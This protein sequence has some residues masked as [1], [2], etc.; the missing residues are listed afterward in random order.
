MM[1]S[2]SLRSANYPLRVLKNKRSLRINVTWVLWFCF[3]LYPVNISGFGVNYL[4]I[5]TPFFYAL[6]GGRLLSPPNSIYHLIILFSAIYIIATFYQ[7]EFYGEGLRRTI[8]YIL[9]MSIFSLILIRATSKQIDS[10][11]FAAIAISCI[12]SIISI[13]KLFALGLVQS[14]VEA[15]DEVGSQRYGFFLIFSFWA[16]FIFYNGGGWCSK[17]IILFSSALIFIGL[18]LTFSRASVV[19]FLASGLLFMMM[20]GNRISVTRLINPLTLAACFSIGF[21]LYFTAKNLFPS[22]FL[23]M[24]ER[25]FDF[26]ISGRVLEHIA[27]S[28]TSE[29][30]RFRIWAA[31]VDYVIRNPVTGSG[32]LGSWAVVQDTGSA[33]NQYMDILLRTGIIGFVFFMVMFFRIWKFLQEMNRFLLVGFSGVLVFGLFHETFKEPIGAV[34]LSFLLSCY[35]NKLRESRMQTMNT[36]ATNKK[37]I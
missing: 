37:I 33:H 29:G 34:L 12:I 5:L 13:Y 36:V 32:F 4:F 24:Q 26:F 21:F 8:S 6:S 9:F 14:A 19:S 28:D 27:D 11:L 1:D 23:F 31:I 10:F 35:A 15:K 17:V 18:I 22:I 25:L 16:L 30:T 20:R 7:F 2:M 3:C